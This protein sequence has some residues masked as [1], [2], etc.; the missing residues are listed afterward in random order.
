MRSH[1]SK[2]VLYLVFLVA[3]LAAATA[4]LHNSNL[5]VQLSALLPFNSEPLFIDRAAG[6]NNPNDP[7]ITESC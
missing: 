2:S 1:I 6:L 5:E 3:S 7:L 4:S